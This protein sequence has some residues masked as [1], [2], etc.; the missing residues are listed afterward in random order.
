MKIDSES[1]RSMVQM[2]YGS[3]IGIAMVLT[4]FGG[5]F[6]G[7][8]LDQKFGGG[9]T[10]TFLFMILGI[11]IGFFESY[12]LIKRYFKDET[13]VIRMIKSE[14]HRKRPSPNKT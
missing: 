5:L 12:K 11:I 10:F 7:S 1:R 4:V 13:Q 8:Y 3:S 9:H 6:F 14:P 2:A